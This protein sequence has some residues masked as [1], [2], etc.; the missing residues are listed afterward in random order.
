M[1]KPGEARKLAARHDKAAKL[2][3]LDM[4]IRRRAE[5]GFYWMRLVGAGWKEAVESLCA[6]GY[7]VECYD[8]S[9]EVAWYVSWE[10]DK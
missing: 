6:E 8:D 5:D 2:C 3:Q 7:R 10:P 1:I 9:G 4:E